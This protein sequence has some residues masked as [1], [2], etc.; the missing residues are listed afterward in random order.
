MF[1]LR[2]TLPKRFIE[3]IADKSDDSFSSWRLPHPSKGRRSIKLSLS[4]SLREDKAS[5][6]QGKDLFSTTD[7]AK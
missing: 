1:Q 4:P 5:E 3:E 6:E 2:R 7:K